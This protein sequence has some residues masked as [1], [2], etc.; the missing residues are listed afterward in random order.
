MGAI[1]VAI[2]Y[3]YVKSPSPQKSTTN[4]L[5]LPIDIY[6]IKGLD[7]QSLNECKRKGLW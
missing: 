5:M 4:S 7:L 1:G 6:N 3:I 2:L